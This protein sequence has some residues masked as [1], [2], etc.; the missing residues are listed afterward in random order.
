MIKYLSLLLLLPTLC[1]SQLLLR[2]GTM[3]NY[4]M[5]YAPTNA[6][7]NAWTNSLLLHA[8]FDGG[9]TNGDFI[10]MSPV[11]DG[12]VT[13]SGILNSS[14]YLAGVSSP[15]YMTNN[16]G[17]ST[18]VSSISNEA[19]MAFWVYSTANL[20]DYGPLFCFTDDQDAYLGWYRDGTGLRTFINNQNKAYYNMYGYLNLNAW[21]HLVLIKTPTNV[22]AYANGIEYMR[23]DHTDSVLWSYSGSYPF[24]LKVGNH[25]SVNYTQKGYY[26]EMCV[27]AR[28]LSSNEVVQLYNG[29]YGFNP[30]TLQPRLL[31]PW[32]TSNLVLFA[33]AES[34]VGSAGTSVT[35]L[36]D[37]SV[38]NVAINDESNGHQFILTNNSS[39]LNG[40]KWMIDNGTNRLRV[41]PPAIVQPYRVFVVMR[42]NEADTRNAF[43][44]EGLNQV[45]QNTVGS[46]WVYC[47]QSSYVTQLPQAIWTLLEINFN[48][49]SSEF[50][51]N[52]VSSGTFNPG[53]A[54]LASFKL[55]ARWN[56]DE[57]GIYGGY[58]AL[59]IYGDLSN[60][61]LVM[62]RNYY[63]TNYN[64]A[65]PSCVVMQGLTNYQNNDN[66]NFTTT[67]KPSQKIQITSLLSVCSVKLRLACTIGNPYQVSFNSANDGSGT[68]YGEVSRIVNFTNADYAWVEFTFTNNPA[69]SND[70]YLCI[71]DVA[72]QTSW[73][74]AYAI[75]EGAAYKGTNY[76][77]YLNGA[78]LLEDDFCFEILSQP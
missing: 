60:D 26:D 45:V 35:N 66:R 3:A 56:T 40:K 38:N 17:W 63:R 43:A 73:K 59:G 71:S 21:T 47:G 42:D 55:G 8:T 36:L 24:A 50:W 18:F 22:I 11:G 70:C 78:A 1:H 44:L 29:G 58:A 34:V 54:D 23:V 46:T 37:Q 67:E 25:I 65:I 77:A 7:P 31:K 15:C 5:A 72:N 69:L 48:G 39:E 30:V 61:K 51:T 12:I 13:N 9:I 4:R 62:I 75:A 10:T 19:T 6:E 41:F 49:A 57:S 32:Q 27:W 52:G 16:G 33:E 76:C 64:L 20:T 28:S 53:T 14:V 2:N 74:E 68:R